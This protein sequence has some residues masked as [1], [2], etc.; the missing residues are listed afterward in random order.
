MSLDLFSFNHVSKAIA[1]PQSQ[2]HS[3]YRSAA[4]AYRPPQHDR[5]RYRNLVHP[6]LRKKTYMPIASEEPR[7][8][9]MCAGGTRTTFIE[10]AQ[11]PR[12]LLECD[13]ASF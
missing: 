8:L 12:L 4:P 9:E 13:S 6:R 3:A 2:R 11:G 5:L 1:A 10:M 7:G